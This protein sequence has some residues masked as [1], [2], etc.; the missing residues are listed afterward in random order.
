MQKKLHAHFAAADGAPVAENVVAVRMVFPEQENGGVGYVELEILG[1]LEA[2]AEPEPE[3]DYVWTTGGYNASTWQPL[4][5]SNMMAYCSSILLS[6]GPTTNYDAMTDSSIDKYDTFVKN[7]ETIAWLYT[8]AMPAAT[9][10]RSGGLRH[11]TRMAS[12]PS[13]RGRKS[14]AWS[15]R[16]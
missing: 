9:A 3:S 12:G 5:E 4:G 10:S 7:G 8:W 1:S 14:I 6:D 2:A 16:A 11:G 15:A 13:G